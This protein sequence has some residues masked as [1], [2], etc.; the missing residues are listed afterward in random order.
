M[1]CGSRF[2]V[3]CRSN[4][5]TAICECWDNDIVRD[6]NM[7]SRLARAFSTDRNLQPLINQLEH[8][9]RCIFHRMV[10]NWLDTLSCCVTRSLGCGVSPRCVDRDCPETLICDEK[11]LA[12]LYQ[13]LRHPDGVI[14]VNRQL[15]LLIERKRPRGKSPSDFEDQL[16]WSYHYLK[17]EYRRT[18]TFI[19]LVSEATRLPKGFTT[20]ELSLLSKDLGRK[21]VVFDIPVLVVRSVISP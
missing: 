21:P 16:L 8:R 20:N 17:S 4:N 15:A 1:V 12:K 6:I 11:A 19:A 5:R 10:S 18:C 9:H 13:G 3:D 14:V 2:L 7:V